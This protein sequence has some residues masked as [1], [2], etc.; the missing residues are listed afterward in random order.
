M[1]L[2]LILPLMPLRTEP[3]II[4]TMIAIIPPRA[5]LIIGEEKRFLPEARTGRLLAEILSRYA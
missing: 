2:S 5:I 4:T 3:K 1:V